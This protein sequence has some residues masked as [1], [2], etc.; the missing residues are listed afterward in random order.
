ML[1][2]LRTCC[3]LLML[4]GL[5]NFCNANEKNNSNEYSSVSDERIY[6]LSEQI[7]ITD[8]GIFLLSD[9][10]ILPIP[11]LNADEQGLF[12]CKQEQYSVT[13]GC[14]HPKRCDNCPGCCHPDCFNR[15]RCSKS[16][17]R[18]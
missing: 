8:A 5:S 16:R 17:T 11:Q 10:G 6:I 1:T 9:D 4:I 15:C 14:N 18:K 2:I 12:V 7:L 3:L 13:K